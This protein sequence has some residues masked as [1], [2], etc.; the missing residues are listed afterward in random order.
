MAKEVKRSV[1]GPKDFVTLPFE[2]GERLIRTMWLAN[3]SSKKDPALSPISNFMAR[4][5]YQLFLQKENDSPLKIYFFLEKELISTERMYED[6]KTFESLPHTAYCHATI[7]VGHVTHVRAKG[8]LSEMSKKEKDSFTRKIKERMDGIK[9]SDQPVFSFSF[10]GPLV[11]FNINNCIA[12]PEAKFYCFEPTQYE[13]CKYWL[14]RVG[15]IK[16]NNPGKSIKHLIARGEYETVK[17]GEI[18]TEKF[19]YL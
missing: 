3:V 15:Q 11:K 9:T 16:R 8:I 5:R 19:P 6:L 12:N 1:T 13:Y 17:D 7:N 10:F 4:F 2:E 18:V 14:C